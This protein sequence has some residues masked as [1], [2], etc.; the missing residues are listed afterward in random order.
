MDQEQRKKRIK[1]AMRRY[2][3]SQKE[4]PSAK[5]CGNKAAPKGS[6]NKFEKH[7]LLVWARI[8]L[9]DRNQPQGEA[10]CQN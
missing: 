4:K 9:L 3:E 7:H 10:P 1:E 8:N 5:R 2:F 6:R